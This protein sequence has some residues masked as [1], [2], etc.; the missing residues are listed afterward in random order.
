MKVLLVHNA[1]QLRGGEDTVVESEAQLLREHGH[2]VV[3]YRR[4]N[5]EIGGSGWGAAVDTLWSSRTVRE[6]KELVARHRPD[7]LHAHNTFPLI[8]PSLYWAADAADLPVV[9]TL[10]NFRL[11]CPQAMLLREGRVCE[12]CVGN[13]P[14]PG[15]VHGCY[16]DSRAK[17]AAVAGMLV[18]HRAIG[19]WQHKVDRYIALNEFCRAK[20]VQGG[21]PAER[22]A[23]KP[24]FVAAVGSS[25][26]ARHGLLFVGRLSAEKGVHVLLAAATG[27]AADTLTV[28]GTGPL[29]DS[30][31]LRSDIRS[32]GHLDSSQVRAQMEATCALVFPSIWYETFGLVIVEAFA[33]GTPVIA[34]RLGVVGD[35]V[36]D[37][38]NGLLVEPG[39]ADDLKQKMRWALSHPQEMAEMGARGRLVYERRF[40]PSASHE[41]TMQIYADAIVSRRQRTAARVK[42]A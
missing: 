15:V 33:A 7:V 24:N 8:S 27:L 4:S 19:T 31:A 34:S 20:F 21:L 26:A 18:M 11:L 9:Q 6:L 5:D 39:N 41:R 3:E 16:R 29:G 23:V 40:T 12:D 13:T 1:Y 22:I 35:L 28:V 38:V 42:S 10:H 32:L 14:W 36:V 17:S 25:P 30:V 2:D 37:G